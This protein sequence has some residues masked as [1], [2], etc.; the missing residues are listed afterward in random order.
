MQKVLLATEKF[1][2]DLMKAA[3]REQR[4]ARHGTTGKLEISESEVSIL[5]HPPKKLNADGVEFVRSRRGIRMWRLPK[6]Q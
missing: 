2:Q 6:G 4:E 5:E 3:E 1:E